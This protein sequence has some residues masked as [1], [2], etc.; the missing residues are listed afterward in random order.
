[1]S[2]AEKSVVKKA[3]EYFYSFA[4]AHSDVFIFHDYRFM[5]ETV[6]ISKEIAKAEDLAKSDYEPALAALILA[7][8]GWKNATDKT[9]DNDTLINT[10]FEQIG[11]DDIE[12]NSIIYYVNFLIANKVPQNKIERVLRDSKDIHLGLPDALERLSVLQAQ[13]EKRYNKTLS[14]LEWLEQCKQY[15]ITHTFD[16]H[17]A[18]REYGATRSK[19]YIELEKRLEKLRL[20]QIKEK[21]ITEKLNG[22]Y[23]LT[24]KENE[25]LFRI[26]FRNYINL[27]ALA[28]SKAGLLIQV[29]SILASVVVALV[30][31]KLQYDSMYALPTAGLLVGSAA[32]IFYSILASKPLEGWGNKAFV[33]DKKE[34]FFFGSFDRLDPEFKK[35]TWEKY[36][37]DMTDFFNGEKKLIFQEIIKESYEV[38]KVLSK[39]FNYLSIAYKVFFAGLLVSIIGFLIVIRHDVSKN[40]EKQKNTPSDQVFGLDPDNREEP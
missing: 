39:K 22:N 40:A 37:G 19:N 4:E 33:T 26:A 23:N 20:E 27:I 24:S 35:V 8:L 9:F 12:K 14:A 15:F 36:L 28:D 32:T 18:N 34:E 29:N 17:Y 38:R 2:K 7:D 16:T 6:I 13:E 31:K 10:F 30:L 1:M 11:I 25:D 3:L 5:N 21:R